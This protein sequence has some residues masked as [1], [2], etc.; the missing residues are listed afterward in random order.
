MTLETTNRCRSSEAET[1][2]E[3]EC[4]WPAGPEDTAGSHTE[5]LAKARAGHIPLEA[6]VVRIGDSKDVDVVEDV[7]GL[8]ADVHVVALLPG[9][10]LHEPEVQSEEWMTEINVGI[11]QGNQSSNRLDDGRILIIGV[12]DR[13]QLR[14]VVH[15]PVSGVPFQSR[16]AKETSPQF[17]TQIGVLGDVE[18]HAAE[19][20]ENRCEFNAP[21]EIENAGNNQAVPCGEVG[22]FC[23][24]RGF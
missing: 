20:G 13:I 9:E 22:R 3:L 16:K 7:E 14:T 6:S 2:H 5:W 23:A 4:A 12:D 10:P 21:R 19:G 18:R 1:R 11:H 8:P 15:L 24:P 17:S